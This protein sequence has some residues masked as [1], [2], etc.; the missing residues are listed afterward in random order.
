M[1]LG[2]EHP[3]LLQPEFKTASPVQSSLGR[4]LLY[5]MACTHNWT[6]EGLYLAMAFLQTQPTEADQ[7]L[8]TRGVAELREA[9][10]LGPNDIMKILKKIYGSTTA[11]RGLWLDLHRRSGGKP[12]VGERC[13]WIWQSKVDKD[14]HNVCRTL[15][16]MGGHVDDFPRC[17]DRN[18]DEWLEICRLIDNLYEWGTAKRGN[19]RHAGTDLTTTIDGQGRVEVQVNQDHYIETLI[20]VNIA[21]DRLRQEQAQLTAEEIAACHATWGSLQRLALQ[22]QLQLCARCNFIASETTTKRNMQVARELQQVIGEVRKQYYSLRFR[23]P[24]WLSSPSATRHTPI[25]RT[26]APLEDC[27]PP[28]LDHKPSRARSPSWRHFAGAAGS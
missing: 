20:D 1:L 2:Y 4:N 25:V 18:S 8:W 19:Y 6:L 23:K 11:P 14:E 22:T 3:D 21:P 17:G 28:H 27:C 15:G 16:M 12:L 9:L 10:G 5:M 13:I 26:S 24:D 7:N